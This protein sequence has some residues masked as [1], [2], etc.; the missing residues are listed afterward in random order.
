MHVW[1]V[2]SSSFTTTFCIC[3][4]ALDNMTHASPATIAAILNNMYLD[5]L[6][7]STNT[8]AEAMTIIREMIPLLVAASFQ[9]TKWTS[10]DRAL[11]EGIPRKHH[12]SAIRD[13]DLTTDDMP[14]QKAMGLQWLPEEDVLR[15]KVSHVVMPLTR[16]GVLQRTHVNFDPVGFSAPFMLEGKLIF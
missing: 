4:A 8:C 6:L 2:N 12:A 16:R 9:L 15:I 7:M 3:K 10:N 13:L 5:D 11:L 1:G 14:M